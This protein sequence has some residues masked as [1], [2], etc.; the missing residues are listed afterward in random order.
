MKETMRKRLA[1]LAV[2]VQLMAPRLFA[3]AG[4]VDANKIPAGMDAPLKN[5]IA[6]AMGG[7][8]GVCILLRFVYDIIRANGDA[9]RGPE[10]RKKAIINLAVTILL[11]LF[12]VAIVNAVFSG[13][14]SPLLGGFGLNSTDTAKT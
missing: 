10:L 6:L 11:L 1:A 2:G 9:D 7:I 14:T 13:T 5:M 8:A 3:D 12:I 4:A